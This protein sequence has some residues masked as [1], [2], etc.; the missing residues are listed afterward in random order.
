MPE[1][2]FMSVI[3]DQIRKA[4]QRAE[5]LDIEG[6]VATNKDKTPEELAT[7]KEKDERLQFLRK[8]LESPKQANEFFERIIQ[9][10]DLQDVNYLARGEIAAH[11]IGR[12]A[13]RQ[14]SGSRAGWGTGF[15]IAPGVLLT[16]HHVLPEARMAERSEVHF[17]H[18]RDLYGE[19]VP[20]ASFALLPQKL[21][22]ADQKLDFAVVAVAPESINDH[23]QLSLFGYLPL[24]GAT[25]KVTDGEWLSIIQH[26]NGELK[27]LC[28]R[29]NKLLK[30]DDDVLWYSTDTVPGSS[31]SPVVNND[32]FVVALHH[33]GVADKKDGKVQTMDGRDFD[34]ARDDENRIK[35]IA[36]EGIRVSRIV[37]ALRKAH[38]EHP[39]L[40]PV[41][42]ATPENAKAQM[43]SFVDL[44]VR[45]YLN[46]NGAVKPDIETKPHAPSSS[47]KKETPAMNTLA[48]PRRINVALDIDAE[49]RVTVASQ[50]NGHLESSLFVEKTATKKKQPAFDAP[51][52]S[53]YDS[54]GG[55]QV[56]FLKKG[57]KATQVNLPTMSKGL[58]SKASPLLEPAK[59]N[60]H[61]L[62]YHN[63]S[64][65]MHAKRRFAIYTAANVRFDQRYE[66]SRPADV[67]RTDPRIDPDHQVTNFYYRGNKFD[68]GHL[69]RREDLEFGGTPIDALRSAADTCHWTNCTPQHEKFNQNKELW[70]GIERYLLEER[71][72][73]GQFHTQV[74]TGP[75]LEEDDP[76]YDDF[77]NIQYP[78]RFWKVIAALDA[79][80]KLFATAYILDQSD[81][82]AQFG[83]EATEVPFG[84]YKT[85]QVKIKEIERLTGLSFTYGNGAAKPLSDLD[86]LEKAP[87]K[88]PKRNGNG[89]LE[90]AMESAPDG[91][92]PLGSLT[93]IVRP[94]AD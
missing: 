90:S 70:Q 9:G 53:D 60:K 57:N 50:S 91:Y 45:G 56:D 66:M 23:R 77:P 76:V 12:I 22:H 8:T 67:W 3:L 54:R 30:R 29:E 43:R 72:L 10:N 82:I 17:A 48:A 21:F 64:L 74:I 19:Q 62:H 94:A 73:H 63:Y 87:P 11:S 25:G 81:V 88:K 26:P 14:P 75:V 83:I 33:S 39:L 79:K 36:N 85:Y 46:G 93:D 6:L 55:F 13:I 92:V 24:V 59:T 4:E 84:A 7:P 69:T 37:D 16:N 49:G 86:P 34:P 80:G 58:E 47:P 18:E 52:D 31:G 51:F 15:L 89:S 20:Y 41:F 35:W 68:R 65:V 27:Q 2:P 78:V 1:A 40:K 42:E 61:V 28:V 32:W 71:I 5:H 38:P 44:R